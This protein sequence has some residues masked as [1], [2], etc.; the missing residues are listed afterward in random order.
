MPATA[1]EDVV[2]AGAGPNGLMLACE[3]SLAGVRPLV[4]ERLPERTQENRANGLV[5]QVV[6]MLDR[7][8]LY[9]RLSGGT[10]PPSPSPSFVFGAMPLDLR[11]L[12]DNPL[13]GLPV[14]QRRVE[15]MLEERATELG[16]RIR[17]G[18]ELTGLS[19]DDQ[20][21]TAEV[22][23]PDGPYRLR[24]RYLVGAD[25]GHSLTRKLSGIGFPGVTTDGTISRTA[26][27]SIPPAMI[28]PATGGLD[29][30]GYGIIPPFMHHRTE[31]GLFVFAPFPSGPPLL[32]T[33]EWDPADDGD[34]PLTVEELRESVQ[35]VLGADLPLGPPP[36]QGPHLLR[37]GAGRNTRLAGR[38]R[39]RRVLLAGDAAHVHSAIGGPGLN[40]GLQDT[41]NLGWKLAAEIH[42]WAPPGLLD[43]Y[44]TE[45]RPAAERVVM[46]TQAQTA[47]IKPG[48]EITALRELFTE[49]LADRHNVQ[50]VADMMAGADIRYDMG[51]DDPHPLVGRWAPDLLLDTPTGHVRLAGLTATARPL[52]LDLT[53]DASPAKEAAAWHDRVD[54]LTTR[55]LDPNPPAT[56]LLL[57]PDGYIAWASAA[58]RPTPHERDTLHAALTRWFG[59]TG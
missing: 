24:T 29:V 28:D 30:P 16:V 43:S 46:H 11:T 1:P 55:C 2:I 15:Q 18:H 25:G 27:V 57:R 48:G 54:T 23:G 47:L 22:T 13:Y 17:R 52:L 8:G 40:L 32:S 56:A 59:A 5:G 34:R 51:I 39:D 26:H 45:R 37:R 6:R 9:Q 19:Q 38:F 41:V 14:P 33:T 10:E 35:R 7:R 42:G 31:R 4:L 53:E 3:L 49:L 58:P 36:G 12:D 50:H 44:E 21:V 20:G